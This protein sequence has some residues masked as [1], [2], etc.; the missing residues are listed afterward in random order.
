VNAALFVYRPEWL[1]TGTTLLFISL[2]SLWD[3]RWHRVPN[4]LTYPTMVVGVVYHTLTA[5]WD[6]ALGSLEGLLI[7]GGLLFVPFLLGGMGAGDLKMLAA[8]GAW[9]GPGSIV[10]IFIAAALVGGV[11][12]CAILTAQGQMSDTVKRYWLMA[13]SLLWLGRVHY[14][15]PSPEVERLQLPYGVVIA[16]G[17]ILWYVAGTISR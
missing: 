8:L 2:V 12:A 1:L 14:L 7:G 9:W 13:K 5:G 15:N 17:V 11:A 10:Q 6:G 4:L 16:C 3:W